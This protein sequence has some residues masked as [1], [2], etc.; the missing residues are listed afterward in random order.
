MGNVNKF[1]SS[2]ILSHEE[3]QGTRSCWMSRRRRSGSSPQGTNNAVISSEHCYSKPYFSTRFINYLW[4][5]T[6]HLRFSGILPGLTDLA[7]WCAFFIRRLNIFLWNRPPWKVLRFGANF[8]KYHVFI[9][10]IEITTPFGWNVRQINENYYVSL[11][12]NRSHGT[13][14]ED[15]HKRLTISGTCS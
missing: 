13:I 3:E 5:R 10:N 4:N 12:F 14:L 7:K 1:A 15:V 9:I 6:I 2:M 8:E 11:A